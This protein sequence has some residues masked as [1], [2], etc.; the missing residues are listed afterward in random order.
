MQPKRVTQMLAVLALTTPLAAVAAS[1]QK[2]DFS[3][4]DSNGDGKV[5]ISEATQAGVPKAEAK[6]EDI[7]NNDQLS[8]TDWDFVDMNPDG[9]SGSESSS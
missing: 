6:R 5:S 1:D 3:E 9:Q 8:K 4:V 7:D 2:P